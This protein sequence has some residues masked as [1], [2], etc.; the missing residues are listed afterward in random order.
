MLTW[1][2]SI[3]FI[4]EAVIFQMPFEWTHPLMFRMCPSSL[5]H[6]PDAAEANYSHDLVHGVPND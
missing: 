5:T 3:M 1:K 2:T 6:T 4:E